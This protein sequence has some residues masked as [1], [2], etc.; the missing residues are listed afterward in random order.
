MGIIFSTFYLFGAIPAA[1]VLTDSINVIE[2][3]GKEVLFIALIPIVSCWAFIYDGFYVGLTLTGRMMLSTFLASIIFF[4]IVFLF[5]L[6]PNQSGS[7]NANS[8]IWTGFLSYLAIRGIFLATLWKDSLS[9]SM[10]GIS[11]YS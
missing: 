8:F 5:T 11:D 10:K 9:K 3:I 6:F 7:T 4:L 2:G 1:S